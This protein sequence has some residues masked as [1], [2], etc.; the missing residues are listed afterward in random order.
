V[1]AALDWAFSSDGDPQIG[2]SLTVVVVS[3]WVQLS[4]LGECRERIEN[5]RS[6]D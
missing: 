6:R 5:G 2:A 3:L 1:R 4:L